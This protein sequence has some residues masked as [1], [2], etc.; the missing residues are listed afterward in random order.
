MSEPFKPEFS[1]AFERAYERARAYRERSE[2]VPPRPTASLADLRGAFGGELPEDGRDPVAIIDQLADAGEQGLIGITSPHFFGWVM[3]ASHP[4]ATAAEFL[5]AAW[6]QNAGIY[7]TSPANAVAEEVSAN[8]LLELLDLPRESS[9]G[10]ST[11][12]TMASFI[13]LSAARTDVLRRTGWDLEENGLTA[14]PEVH[15][16]LSQQA[17]ATIH[18]GLR[19]L[20]F[21][22]KQKVAIASDDQCRMVTADLAAKLPLYDGPKIIIS[23]AGQINSGAFDDFGAISKLARQHGA[24]H[25]VD[26]AFGLWAR[27]VPDLAHFCEGIDQ[28]DSWSVDGHKWLQVP[29]D[30]GFAIVKNPIAHMRAMDTSASYIAA[31]PDDGRNPS[32][33]GPELSRRAR[34][35]AVWATIQALGRKGIQEMI[36]RHVACAQ[37]LA[38][39]VAQEPGIRVLNDVVI[40]QVAIAF[41][42]EDEPLEA[43]NAYAPAVVQKIREE[44][45]SYV[46][47]AMWKDEQILRVSVISRTTD[48]ADVEQLGASII[49]AWRQVRGN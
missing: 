11:G 2:G 9:L 37:H 13:C 4:V 32:Q 41:G 22:E 12:A 31:G 18:S 34:G 49:R 14:A 10:F 30:S 33:F 46:G 36:A 23:Q 21:G 25:H 39:Q 29:Y 3:G 24:W 1:A 20:G 8:W 45:T 44:N 17:H 15:V 42:G 38:A 26:G 47:G 6:G 48:I 43:R 19:Y 40:N 35:F 28:A 16:F 7:Q 27:A 5:T